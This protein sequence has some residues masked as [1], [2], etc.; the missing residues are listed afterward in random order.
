MKC[1]EREGLNVFEKILQHRC[2]TGSQIWLCLRVNN[3][4][5]NIHNSIRTVAFTKILQEII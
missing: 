1:A 3:K 5:V 2:L 4:E